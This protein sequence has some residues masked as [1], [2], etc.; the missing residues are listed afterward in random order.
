MMKIGTV[1]GPLA[2]NNGKGATAVSELPDISNFY[3]SLHT[4]LSRE[5]VAGLYG[6]LGWQIRKCSWTD[7]E[8]SCPWAELAIEAES[9]ILMHGAVADVLAHA[10]ELVAPLRVAGVSFTAECYGPARELLRVLSA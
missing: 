6:A 4:A 10:D 1:P 8:V 2:P 3:G 5:Q 7:Y 9:P